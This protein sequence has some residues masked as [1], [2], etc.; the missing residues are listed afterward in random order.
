MTHLKTL[1]PIR[2]VCD[3]LTVIAEDE[4]IS[5]LEELPT[6]AAFFPFFL[7]L[8][9]TT[10]DDIFAED[11]RGQKILRLYLHGNG[12]EIQILCASPVSYT[13]DRFVEEFEEKEA[14]MK[15]RMRKQK[16]FCDDF[17]TQKAFGTFTATVYI[18]ALTFHNK[19]IEKS[20]RNAQ[21]LPLIR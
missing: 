20:I 9:F 19:T 13:C 6:F 18:F 1:G 10:S 2:L 4:M 7:P 21:D 17:E 11:F 16:K 3:L 15:D 8:P 5:L 12:N 14:S